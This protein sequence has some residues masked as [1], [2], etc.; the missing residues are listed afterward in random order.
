[1][2]LLFQPLN[3]QFLLE[4]LFHSMDTICTCSTLNKPLLLWGFNEIQC[5]PDIIILHFWS[6]I[7]TGFQYMLWAAHVPS[8]TGCNGEWQGVLEQWAGQASK[9]FLWATQSQREMAMLQSS[10]RITHK[11]I[12]TIKTVQ[13]SGQSHSVKTGKLAGGLWSGMPGSQ[14]LARLVILSKAGQSRKKR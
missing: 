4:P 7:P 9:P 11:A 1:M 13:S 3:L 2:F 10:G 14:A 12:E 5:D 6:L 8:P